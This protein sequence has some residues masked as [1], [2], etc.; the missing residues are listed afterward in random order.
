M[1]ALKKMDDLYDKLDFPQASA[2]LRS[3]LGER[4]KRKTVGENGGLLKWP[5]KRK[6][7]VRE[8]ESLKQ[9]FEYGGAEATFIICVKYR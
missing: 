5:E 7:D 1:E 3:F 9:V 4:S 6:K 2:E 8:M